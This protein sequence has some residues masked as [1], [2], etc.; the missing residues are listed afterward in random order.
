MFDDRIR[1]EPL[2]HLPKLRFDVVSVLPTVRQ[3]QSKH[4]PHP[5]IFHTLETEGA[6]GVLDRGPLRVEDRRLKFYG[7]SRVQ[8]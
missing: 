2:T 8:I 4:L 3:R 7:Y 6:E 5:D 1:E